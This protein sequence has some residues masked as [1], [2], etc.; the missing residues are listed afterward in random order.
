MGELL[1]QQGGAVVSLFAHGTALLFSFFDDSVQLFLIYCSQ[2]NLRN[3]FLSEFR[4]L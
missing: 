4:K 3:N 1:L 2:L